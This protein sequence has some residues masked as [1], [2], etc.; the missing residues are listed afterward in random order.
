MLVRSRRAVLFI[1]AAALLASCAS[2]DFSGL[3]PTPADRAD[4]YVARFGPN[5]AIPSFDVFV[6]GNKVGELGSFLG[7]NEYLRVGVAPGRSQIQVKAVVNLVTRE[8]IERIVDLDIT[9]GSRGFAVLQI[10]TRKP[11]SNRVLWDARLT[12]ESESR[13]TG[14]LKG[15]PFRDVTP[16]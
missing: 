13:A 9:A 3:A 8:T 7:A 14:L 12:V 1:G 5:T 4:I 2:S 6:N 11:H 16:K 15:L 10:V